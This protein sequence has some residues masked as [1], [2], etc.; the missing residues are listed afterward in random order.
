[1]LLQ[2]LGF[3]ETFVTGAAGK[4]FEV[5]GHVFPQ[6]VLLMETFVTQLAEKAL[7]FVQLPPPPPLLLLL[8]LLSHTCRQEPR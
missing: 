2:S 7:L 5:T 6:L 8:L 1:M 3:V 4:R